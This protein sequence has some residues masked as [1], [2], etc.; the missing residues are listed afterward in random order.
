MTICN[1]ARE[2]VIVGALR[3]PFGKR[4]GQLSGWHPVE[5][6]SFTLKGLIQKTGVNP[7]EVE[8]VIAGCV[9]QVGEQALNVARNAWLDAGLPETTPGTTV[10]RQCGSGMQA[11]QFAA[12]GVMAGSYDLVMAGGVARMTR[13]PLG[14]NVLLAG[15]QRPMTPAIKSR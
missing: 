10:D 7:E 3:T 5:L 9:D 4:A 12:Q 8:D 13:V 1:G 6:L 14:A 15:S 11:L 2:A